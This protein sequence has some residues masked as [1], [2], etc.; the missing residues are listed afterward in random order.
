V[1][2][3]GYLYDTFVTFTTWLIP[4]HEYTIKDC[5][6]LSLNIFYFHP[7]KIGLDEQSAVRVLSLDPST[8][9]TQI[10][11]DFLSHTH[12]PSHNRYPNTVTLH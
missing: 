7:G 10:L 1:S 12:T 11:H 6:Y 4:Y 8:E 5:M 2:K 3:T 9:T